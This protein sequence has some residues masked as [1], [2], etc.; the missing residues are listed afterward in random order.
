M[1][2]QSLNTSILDELA[3]PQT[4]PTEGANGGPLTARP[5]N[6]TWTI[7]SITSMSRPGVA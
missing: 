2:S 4:V 3:E 7:F 6:R 5:R 1:H